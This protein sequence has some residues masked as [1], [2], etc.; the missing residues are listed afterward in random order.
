MWTGARRKPSTACATEATGVLAASVSEGLSFRVRPYGRAEPGRC[1]ER[2]IVS[3]RLRTG[4]G[5]QLKLRH[6]V[7]RDAGRD[8]G[9]SGRHRASWI[10]SASERVPQARS[11]RHRKRWRAVGLAPTVGERIAPASSRREGRRGRS[12]GVNAAA[13]RGVWDRDPDDRCAERPF[14]K[15]GRDLDSVGFRKGVESA[16]PRRLKATRAYTRFDRPRAD[17]RGFRRHTE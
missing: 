5:E 4:N 1:T 2:S 14:P 6:G 15:R 11:P 16:S 8:V 9:P 7:L 17:R 13:T 3:G 10:V 12:V